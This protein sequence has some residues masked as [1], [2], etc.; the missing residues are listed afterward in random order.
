MKPTW[1]V[2]I[3]LCAAACVADK[4][5]AAPAATPAINAVDAD[6]ERTVRELPPAPPPAMRWLYIFDESSYE[7]EDGAP[8]ADICGVVAICDGVAAPAVE[9]DY[10]MGDGEFCT[11]PGRV[12]ITNRAD[13]TAALDDGM[14]CDWESI[15]SDYV[16]LGQHGSITLGFERAITGCE[17]AVRMTD[18]DEAIVA[19]VCDSADLYAANCLNNDNPVFEGGGPEISFPV[20]AD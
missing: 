15:P 7:A 3:A 4:D 20:S 1:I 16:A 10:V 19:F 9:A 18:S 8:G 14:T 17:I 13:P 6:E 11:E 5:D 12:C 2:L